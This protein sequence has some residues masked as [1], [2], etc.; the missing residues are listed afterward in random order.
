MLRL[1]LKAK[2]NEKKELNELIDEFIKNNSLKISRD[3]DEFLK[4]LRL[5]IYRRYDNVDKALLKELIKIKLKEYSVDIDVSDIDDIYEKMATAGA[6]SAAAALKVK[7]KISFDRVDV[8]AIKAMKESFYWS[9]RE[10]DKRFEDAI[11]E[12]IEEVFKGNIPRA[13]LNKILESKYGE[14]LKKD[15]KYFKALADHI[16]NQSQNIARVTGALKYNIKAFRVMARIDDRTSDICR[17]MH[18][19]IISAAHL[20]RQTEAL[21]RAKNMN[22][23]KAA[24]IWL[25]K[26]LFGKLPEN[27]G[28][29]P[30]HFRCRTTILPVTLFS[31]TVD[32]KKVYYSHKED[33]DVIAHIDKSGV[34]RHIKKDFWEHSFSAKIRDVSKKDIIGA[35]NSIEAIA[36]HKEFHDRFVAKSKNGYFLVFEANKVISAFK[37]Q[38]AKGKSNLDDYFKRSSKIDKMEIIK[39]NTYLKSEKKEIGVSYLIKILKQALKK[40]L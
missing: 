31:D 2:A 36:P 13:D 9:G 14:L 34:E 7:P 5:F 25:N 18:G 15:S 19:R 37:P 26:P 10:Y 32:G 3:L 38:N 11:K 39:W 23:K 33:G 28:L 29:P 27:F 12:I 8:E 16:I 35:L 21:L 1:L 40:I 17:S 22:E 20:K 24:A 4:E 6:I 30:Y